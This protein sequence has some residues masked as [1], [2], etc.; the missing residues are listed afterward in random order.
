M[1]ESIQTGIKHSV[2]LISGMGSINKAIDILHY[3][4]THSNGLSM[5]E[6]IEYTKIP[7]STAKRIIHGLHVRG[8]IVQIGKGKR[9][10]VNSIAFENRSI[11][12]YEFDLS[13][14]VLFLQHL[15]DKFQ[16]CTSLYCRNGRNGQDAYA[17]E[18]RG[19][20]TIM[21]EYSPEGLLL[22]LGSVVPTFGILAAMDPVAAHAVIEANRT[23]IEGF[24]MHSVEYVQHLVKLLRSQGYLHIQGAWNPNRSH[25]IFP[26]LLSK[27]CEAA[28]C[29][30]TER[31]GE[32]ANRLHEVTS[33]IMRYISKQ[34]LCLSEKGSA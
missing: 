16:V 15:V 5:Q 25:A 12:Q 32:H 3:I 29:A 6:I 11:C 26:L 23:R 7:A 30:N 9:Y 10:F 28:L 18:R 24:E 13:Q 19:G 31:D 33:Y 4:S 20:H 17:I 8:V 27:G 21:V 1:S 2:Q 22:P 34:T 14:I